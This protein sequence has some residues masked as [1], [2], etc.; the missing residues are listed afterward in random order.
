MVLERFLKPSSCPTLSS[1][2][3]RDEDQWRREDLSQ[4]IVADKIWLVPASPGGVPVPCLSAALGLYPEPRTGAY[5]AHLDHELV[6][7]FERLRWAHLPGRAEAGCSPGTPWQ[8]GSAPL[9]GE[10][11]QCGCYYPNDGL[12]T[13]AR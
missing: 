7:R 11:G 2:R 13:S 9:Q 4:V 8:P 3:G 5:I 10:P 12:S 1:Y 6:S